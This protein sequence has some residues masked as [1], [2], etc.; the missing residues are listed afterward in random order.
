MVAQYRLQRLLQQM[1]R[2]SGCVQVA[3]RRFFVD[4]RIDSYRRHLDTYPWSR[5]RTWCRYLPPRVLAGHPVTS[6]SP[7]PRTDHAVCHACLT[8]HCQR[9]TGSRP[10]TM[11]PL[12]PSAMALGQLARPWS[13]PVISASRR[14]FIAYSRQKFRRRRCPG[15]N[16]CRPRPGRPVTSRASRARTRLLLHGS[17]AKPSSSTV[18]PSSSRPSPWSGRWGSRRYH[19]A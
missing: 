15:R 9:R 13:V 4:G 14:L 19:K 7:L 8:A 1:G 2:A 12:S 11:M 17:L 18:M 5:I 16:R 3:L 10:Q 6:N